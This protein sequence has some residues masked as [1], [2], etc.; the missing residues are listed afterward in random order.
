MPRRTPTSSFEQP[1]AMSAT[2]SRCRAVIGA[3]FRSVARSIMADDAT[4][5]FEGR[6]LASGCKGRCNPSGHRNLAENLG[7]DAIQDLRKALS[8][9]GDSVVAEPDDGVRRIWLAGDEFGH[10]DRELL[11]PAGVIHVGRGDALHPGVDVEN[12]ADVGM[13]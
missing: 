6:P 10:R 1:A 13:R 8:R 12:R 5:P 7:R 2:T 9:A 3:V 11:G 4:P